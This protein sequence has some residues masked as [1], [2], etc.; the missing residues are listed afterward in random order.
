MRR[1]QKSFFILFIDVT[2]T[3][4]RE[5]FTPFNIWIQRA[6][7]S[8][9]NAKRKTRVVRG[10]LQC[11]VKC[12]KSAWR[13]SKLVSKS[14]WELSGNFI[15]IQIGLVAFFFS[16]IFSS[17][18]KL[19]KKRTKKKK[20][21]FSYTLRIQFNCW[22]QDS[23]SYSFSLTLISDLASLDLE[24]KAPNLKLNSFPWNKFVLFKGS[25]RLA[26]PSRALC[27]WW[28]VKACDPW[29]KKARRV[30]KFAKACHSPA[31]A[32]G[33]HSQDWF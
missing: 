20:N 9:Q 5:T 11:R 1:Q 33:S 8:T 26:T 12:R 24:S 19:T 7:G 30:E 27:D 32:F 28:H 16:E 14:A 6:R 22:S 23:F 4:A 17:H 13:E 25:N 2:F 3:K 21:F 29:R 18:G 10:M 15:F 31:Y